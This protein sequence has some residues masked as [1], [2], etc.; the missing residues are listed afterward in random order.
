MNFI[1]LFKHKDFQN[2]CGYD[3]VK[4][5]VRRALDSEENFNLLFCGP[6]ASAKTL[7]LL[8][9]MELEPKAVYFDGSNT[10][11]VYWMCYTSRDLSSSF[12]MSSIKCLANSR[13]NC[14][15][16]WKVAE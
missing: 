5:I 15:C 10:T 13:T 14:L 9:I 7:F 2:I 3:D 6:P 8:G 12:W 4:N 1:H 16:F 11:T